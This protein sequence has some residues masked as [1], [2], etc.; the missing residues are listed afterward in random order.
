M[1]LCTLT[2][3][4]GCP[5]PWAYWCARRSAS[6]AEV[7]S[8]SLAALPT[9]VLSVQW[10]SAVRAVFP[11]TANH[12]Y[13]VKFDT[14]FKIKEIFVT[15]FKR[16]KNQLMLKLPQR[17]APATPVLLGSLGD[18]ADSRVC[19]SAACPHNGWTWTLMP[20]EFLSH[21][22]NTHQMSSLAEILVSDVK[23]SN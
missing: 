4:Q 23:H 14:I 12:S 8:A 18:T 13:I 2:A 20:S 22:A 7:C 5:V 15:V 3:V 6:T 16:L 9:L 10:L 17:S 19:P 1:E 21:P 11:P